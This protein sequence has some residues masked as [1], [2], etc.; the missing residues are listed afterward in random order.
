M[1]AL[2]PQQALR[3]NAVALR[4]SVLEGEW[5]ALILGGPSGDWDLDQ[6]G[7]YLTKWDLVTGL[8]ALLHPR[9]LLPLLEEASAGSGD[10]SC[11]LGLL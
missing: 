11:I 9:L 1:D 6:C 8:Q 4:D 10:Q 5:R 7:N 3:Q 2:A